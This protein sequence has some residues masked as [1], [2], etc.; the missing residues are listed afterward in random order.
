MCTRTDAVLYPANVILS[1]AKEPCPEACL[2]R[3]AQ[4]DDGRVH[5][6]AWC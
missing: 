4:D 6:G 5:T 3:F 2:L 1:E